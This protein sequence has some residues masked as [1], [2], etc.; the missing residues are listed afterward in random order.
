L[1]EPAQVIKLI[2]STGFS[3]FF[4]DG[5]IPELPIRGAIPIHPSI[6]KGQKTENISIADVRELINIT[7]TKQT[8]SITYLLHRAEFIREEALHAI[9]KLVEE[10]RDHIHIAFLYTRE[11]PVLPTIRSRAQTYYLRPPIDINRPP[12]VDADI[13]GLAK[14]L[15]IAT[16]NQLPA[17]ADQLGKDRPHL[18]TIID[19]AIELAYKSY[20]KTNSTKFLAT[21][22]KLLT[23]HTS[24]SQ[25]GHI[26]LHLIA[27]ML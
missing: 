14:Q 7:K 25:N 20:Y 1:T 17:L 12:A 22:E 19:T 24:I 15:L 27:D 4:F 23:L 3:I 9:L 11:V 21:L 10:P 16:P 13:L 8:K 2:E 6:H 18:L 5:T 26:K